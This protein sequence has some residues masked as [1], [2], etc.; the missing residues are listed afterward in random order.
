MVKVKYISQYVDLLSHYQYDS[1]LLPR[2]FSMT[3]QLILTKLTL[4]STP[5]ARLTEREAF[6]LKK[7]FK[8]TGLS[9]R[10]LDTD[11]RC[12]DSVFPHVVLVSY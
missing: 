12:R 8:E 9:G 1:L 10:L 4:A 5:T 7:Q 3:L 11:P 6:C 2:N